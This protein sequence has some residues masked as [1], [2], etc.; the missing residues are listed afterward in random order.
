MTVHEVAVVD[1]STIGAVRLYDPAELPETMLITAVTLGELWY[2]SACDGGSA[3]R[4]GR[5][6][7]LQHAEATFDPLAVRRGRGPRLRSDLRRGAGGG[8]R[9]AQEGVGSDDRYYR[10]E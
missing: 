8:V 10:G 3:E 5:V 2:G 6:A 9:T 1:T 7:V 4:A